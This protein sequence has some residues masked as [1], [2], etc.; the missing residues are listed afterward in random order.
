MGLN[1]PPYSIAIGKKNIYFLN[2][3]FEFVERKKIKD[4]EILKTNKCSSDPYDYHL[5]RCGKISFEKLR[6]NK[7]HANYD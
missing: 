1:L 7:S 5:S 4:N 6:M 3:H 2:P